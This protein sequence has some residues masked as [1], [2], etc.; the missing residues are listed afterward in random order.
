MANDVSEFDDLPLS[1]ARADIPSPELHTLLL[2]LS[3]RFWVP[4]A[5]VPRDW[6]FSRLFQERLQS[7]PRGVIL[8]GCNET[9][10][11][12][13]QARGGQAT[14]VGIEAALPVGT[15]VRADV[16]YMARRGRREGE[17]VE[18]VADENNRAQM[19]A[20][21]ASSVHSAKP[22]LQCTFRN[23]FRPPLR[24]FVMI[25][26]GEQWLGAMT[27][28]PMKPGYWHA[29]LL[30][31]REDAPPGVME[32]LILHVRAQLLAE[33]QQWLS[34]GTVPFVT[35]APAG[36]VRPCRPLWS[37][38]CRGRLIARMG[39]LLRFG[40]DY[41]GLYR[42]KNKFDPDWRPLYLCGWPDLPWRILPDLSW[43]SRHMHLVGHAAL[44]R[45]KF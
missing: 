1:W 28:S 17:I 34:L 40:Y 10:A 11:R 42:F 30:L 35:P 14:Q 22:R 33:G 20:L 37:P 5:D 18:V 3:Q 38:S 16:Q 8:Q 19:A 44:Q 4:C 6:S 21:W 23:D 13:L 15:P 24:G 27:L 12:Y 9:L 7:L 25:G 29:E 43:A 32:A 36:D 26:P 45:M 41:R 31:R 39:R 2:P